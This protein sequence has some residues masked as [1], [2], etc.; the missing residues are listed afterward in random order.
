MSLIGIFKRLTEKLGNSIKSTF[1]PPS[2]DFVK[3]RRPRDANYY[4]FRYPSP[5]STPVGYNSDIEANYRFG[6]R[7]SVYN[8]REYEH[9]VNQPAGE[10]ERIDINPNNKN[11]KYIDSKINSAE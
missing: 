11:K 7:D 2:L 1:R 3:N 8:I 4:H 5:G 10:E 9:Y 6:Y